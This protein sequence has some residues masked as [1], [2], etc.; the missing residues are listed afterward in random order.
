MTIGWAALTSE[1]KCDSIVYWWSKSHCGHLPEAAVDALAKEYLQEEPSPPPHAPSRHVSLRF[2]AK[3]S[4]RDLMLTV[5]NLF[6]V[7]DACPL[8]N[9]IRPRSTEEFDALRAARLCERDHSVIL[10]LRDDRAG[11]QVSKMYPDTGSV[12]AGAM[13]RASGCPCGGG[14]QDRHHLLW[15][16]TLPGVRELRRDQL[17]P[18]VQA[19][20]HALGVLDS[21]TKTHGVCMACHN[22]LT[23]T[24]A[25]SSTSDMDGTKPVRLQGAA[26]ADACLALMLGVVR[27]PA[28]GR[29]VQAALKLTRPILR[30]VVEM[31]R[32]IERA[33]TADRTYR[34]RR[35][36]LLCSSPVPR[37]PAPSEVLH[38]ASAAA[39]GWSLCLLRG[40]SAPCA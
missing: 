19:L 26:A 24:C 9:A 16:C 36:A 15:H 20:N 1:Q 18:A 30:T 11:L 5:A 33:S 35:A 39:S 4:E 12:S 22:A 23:A 40:R 28:R 14:P 34:V 2:Y 37:R 10:R 3:K 31:L 32:V 25:P 7:R 6:V 17:A 29:A 13:L 38:M 27:T 21:V 8:G